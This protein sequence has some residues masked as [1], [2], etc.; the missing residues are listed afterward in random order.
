MD[1]VRYLSS[2]A[3]SRETLESTPSSPIIKTIGAALSVAALVLGF[4]HRPKLTL[5]QMFARV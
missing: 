4:K 2:L 1:P 3:P 5:Q